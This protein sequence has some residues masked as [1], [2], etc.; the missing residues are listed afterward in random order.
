MSAWLCTGVAAAAADDLT[1]SIARHAVKV[2]KIFVTSY[3]HDPRRAGI[4]RRSPL[5]ND[6]MTRLRPGALGV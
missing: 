3:V 1:P 5:E 4:V 6:A 2:K